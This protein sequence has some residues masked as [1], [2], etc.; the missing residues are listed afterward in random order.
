LIEANDFHIKLEERTETKSQ[1]QRGWG[2]CFF[3]FES[4][5]EMI[6]EDKTSSSVLA[7]S[8]GLVK[9]NL[10]WCWCECTV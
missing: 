9:P 10:L 1:R 8:A 3:F 2:K 6:W 7:N 4:C 5:R